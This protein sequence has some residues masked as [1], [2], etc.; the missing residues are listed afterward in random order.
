MY[1]IIIP[2]LSQ[3]IFLIVIKVKTDGENPSVFCAFCLLT[4]GGAPTVQALRIS[5]QFIKVVNC[6]RIGTSPH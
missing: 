6:E 3:P 2:E 5:L 1:P 4:F